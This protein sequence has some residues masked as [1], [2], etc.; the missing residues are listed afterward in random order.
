[1]FYMPKVE[2]VMR[3]N[4]LKKRDEFAKAAMAALIA[5]IPLYDRLGECG[6]NTPSVNDIHQVRRDIAQSAYD[7]ADAM[8]DA[9]DM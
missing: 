4:R 8:L 6:I 7:Y 3:A 9:R 2:D 1:M 5:K